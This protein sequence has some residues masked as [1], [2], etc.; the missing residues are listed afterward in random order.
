MKAKINKAIAHLGLEIQG[1][2]GSGCFYFTNAHGALNA[3]LVMVSA[4]THLPV[5]RWV[6]EAQSAL[7]QDRQNQKSLKGLVPVIKL[8]ERIY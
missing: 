6:E 7:E 1:G 3:D 4:M 5:S 8:S 2:N